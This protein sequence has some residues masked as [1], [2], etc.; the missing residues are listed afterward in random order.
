MVPAMKNRLQAFLAAVLLFAATAALFAPSIGFSLV[1]FDDPVF[2]TLNPIVADGFSWHSIPDAFTSLHGDR[3]MYM[4]LL[5]LSYLADTLLFRASP[6]SPWGFHLSNV[7][8]HAANAVLLFFILRRCTRRTLPALLAAAFWALHPLRVESVAWV[9][10]RKDTLSTLFAFLSILFYLKSFPAPLPAPNP[11][12]LPEGA[13]D[14]RSGGG[15]VA[16]PSRKGFQCLALATF[17]LGLLSKPMLVTLPFL[18]LLLDVWPL[19]RTPLSLPAALRA[20]PRLAL[21]KWPFFLLSA[22]C[23]VATKILQADATVQL[24]LLQRLYWLPSNYF[25]YLAKSFYPVALIPMCPGL[26][27]TPSFTLS[28]TLFFLVLAVLALR[29]FRRCPGFAVGLA[30]FA[31]LLFPV[32]GIVFIGNYPVA[33]RYSYLPAIGLTLALAALLDTFTSPAPPAPL[34]EEAPGVNRVGETSPGQPLWLLLL[35]LPLLALAATTHRLLPTWKNSAALYARVAAFLPNHYGVQTYRFGNAFFNTGDLA[36]ARAAADL[37][38]ESTPV[39]PR[40][41]LDEILVRSQTDGTAAALDFFAAHPLENESPLYSDSLHLALAVLSADAARP[42]DAARHLALADAVV[43]LNSVTPDIY[44]S[45]AVWILWRIGRPGEALD[46]LRRASATAAGT[47]LSPKILLRLCTAVWDFGLRRQA[48]PSFLDLARQ[49][50]DDPELLN[51]VA[52]LLATTPA[53]PADPADVLPIARQAL[54]AVPAHPIVRDTY[55][56]ALAFAG[57]FDDAIAVDSAVAAFLRLSPASDAPRVLANVEHRL[58]LF[59]QHR[60]YTEP[61]AAAL[62]LCAFR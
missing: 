37:A 41:L 62:L 21:G 42:D 46:R 23:I 61:T 1:N 20:L 47:A 19:R 29:F 14:R 31:G 18:F 45:A 48:L 16:R 52:W 58:D 24:S 35:L 12:P 3:L 25:F 51:N 38:F 44:H 26:S 40:S 28:V 15:D 8:L 13:P 33:D 32:S 59:R 55:A 27:V 4:P 49:A 54:D 5:W 6:A 34:P 50:P 9:T 57:R 11:G 30:A 39:H 17:I 53:S 43:P 56:T 36:D 60:P 7:L 2:I 22:I 10:E